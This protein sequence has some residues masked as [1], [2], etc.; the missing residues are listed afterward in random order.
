MRFSPRYGLAAGLVLF[1]L[2]GGLVY[3]LTTRPPIEEQLAAADD[4]KPSPDEAAVHKAL[5]SFVSAFNENDAKKVGTTL[6]ANAEYIDEKSNRIEGT[7]AIIDMLTKFFAGSKGAKLQITPEG[8]R[9]VA[10]GVVIEDGESTVTIPEKKTES[11]RKYT[12]VYVKIEG[13]WK[14]ASI[15]EYPEEPEVLTPEERLQDL[16][17]FV[18]EWVDEGGDSLVMNNVRFSTDKTHLIREFSVK[19][20][21]EEVMKGMQWIGVDPLTGTIKGWSFDTSGGR[22]E[23]TWTKNGAQWLV[24]SSGVT[25]DGDESGG[26]Y[27]F[28]LLNKDRIELKVMHKVVG[29]TVEADSTAIMVRKPTAPKK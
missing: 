2:V 17:W 19:Q 9:T 16:A 15:R 29:D 25:S 8:A 20:E 24:R 6:T 7:A 12:M 22:S 13:S 3:G 5:E 26:T 11:V 21:G 23:S 18:G 27:I 1:G 4:S 14:I 28:N 10:P